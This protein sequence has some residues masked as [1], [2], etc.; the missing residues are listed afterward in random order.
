MSEYPSVT[1]KRLIKKLIR[2]G[3]IYC[4]KKGSHVSLR[5][6]ENPLI[7]PVVPDITK[8]LK[9]GTLEGIKKQLRLSRKE[10]IEILRDC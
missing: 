1:G 2:I 6:P 4:R 5:H 7:V 8:D 3:Y 9:K 10:F